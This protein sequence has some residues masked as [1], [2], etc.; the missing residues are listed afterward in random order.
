MDHLGEL[1]PGAVL[2]L[3]V[4]SG[5]VLVALDDIASALFGLRRRTEAAALHGTGNKT[6]ERSRARRWRGPTRSFP[7]RTRR[8]PSNLG[9]M[10]S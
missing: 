9:N 2:A 5:I 1:L 3:L 6:A 7:R 8:P 4:L 10:R